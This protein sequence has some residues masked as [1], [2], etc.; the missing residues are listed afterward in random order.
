MHHRVEVEPLPCS[1]G[2]TTMSV[3]DVIFLAIIFVVMA[4]VRFIPSLF[5]FRKEFGSF[6]HRAKLPEVKVRL[7]GLGNAVGELVLESEQ[8]DRFYNERQRESTK[9]HRGGAALLTREEILGKISSPQPDALSLREARAR[10]EKALHLLKRWKPQ[11]ASEIP[12]WMEDSKGVYGN[13][14]F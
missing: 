4:A 9:A 6:P 8:Y 1:F 14:S 2:R 10:W 12:H 7:R 5:R 3:T 13:R 11:F